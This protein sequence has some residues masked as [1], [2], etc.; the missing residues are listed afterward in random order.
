MQQKTK[1]TQA[2]KRSNFL[3]QRTYVEAL[4]KYTSTKSLQVE[5]SFIGLSPFTVQLNY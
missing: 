3:E 5:D 2:Q 1:H 4:I